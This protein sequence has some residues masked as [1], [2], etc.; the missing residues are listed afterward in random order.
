MN[1]IESSLDGKCAIVSGASRGIGAAIARAYAQAGADVIISGRKS[2]TLTRMAKEIA[3]EFDADVLPVTAHAG[4]EQS[5]QALVEAAV[6]RFGRVD[7]V[8]NNAATNPHFG[9]ILSAEA[10]HWDKIF[11]VNVKG[12]FWLAKA[13]AERMIKQDEGGKIINIASVAGLRPGLMMGVYSV[14]K[15]AVIMLTK[16]LAVELG[17]KRIQ[18]NA[19]APGFIKTHFS[20]ALWQN[21]TLHGG[22]VQSTP[23]G[24]MGEPE[25]LTGIALYLASPASDF[26]TGEVFTIDGGYTL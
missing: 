11:E 18:V 19:I 13:A 4:N 15:A 3:G 21:A 7:I 9:P 26:T 5:G 24:R 1:R 22:I 10:S 14:S 8:V 25:E 17:S 12:Y 6:E 16:A 2:D 23:A 20:K